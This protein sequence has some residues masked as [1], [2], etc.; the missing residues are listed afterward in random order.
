MSKQRSADQALGA[1]Y[2]E[3]NE[4]I[5]VDINDTE[6][7]YSKDSCGIKTCSQI[8]TSELLTENS[9]ECKQVWLQALK[10]NTEAIYFCTEE[11]NNTN[12]PGLYAKD[13]ITVNVKNPNKIWILTEVVSEGCKWRAIE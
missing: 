13:S 1:S 5:A 3:E 2:R 6:E 10:D 8:I 4:V 12:M 11:F 7:V 9:I